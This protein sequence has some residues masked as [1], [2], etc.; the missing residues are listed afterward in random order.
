ML[1]KRRGVRARLAEQRDWDKAVDR[2]G[3]LPTAELHAWFEA[4]LYGLQQTR[5]QY[6]RTKDPL[7]LTEARQGVTSL[8]ALI[9][10]LER[11]PA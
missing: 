11:R 2:V 5:E 9:D 4:S 10:E 8:Y 3:Q 6:E 7:A 1:R